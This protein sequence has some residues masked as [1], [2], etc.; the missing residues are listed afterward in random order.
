V[1]GAHRNTLCLGG[2]SAVK[3]NLKSCEQFVN[4]NENLYGLAPFGDPLGCFNLIKQ[5]QRVKPA[6]WLQND[7]LIGFIFFPAHS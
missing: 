3:A 5:S 6:E 7:I 1:A 2:S 4:H